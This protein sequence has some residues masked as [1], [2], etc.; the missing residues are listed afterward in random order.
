MASSHATESMSSTDTTKPASLRER[1]ERPPSLVAMVTERLRNAIVSGE[2]RLGEAVSEDKLASVF[3]VSRTPVREALTALQ[4]Q[5]LIDIRPQRG[6]FVFLP[7]VDEVKALCEFRMIMEGRAMALS[8]ARNRERTLDAM[9]RAH[10]AMQEALA[11]GDL[12]S[13]T[14]SDAELHDA[15]F[16]NCGNQYLAQAYAHMSGRI[17]TLRTHLSSRQQS[18]AENSM[19]EHREILEALALSDLGRAENLLSVHISRM[20]D[21][22]RQAL[23]SK[24][25]P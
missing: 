21:R 4:L 3:G 12:A 24:A 9:K 16:E 7:S 19:D 17:S 22:Y 6:S 5:G 14:R 15:F 13:L 20:S 11:R 25:L 18:I 8:L 10:A 1:L 23:D 2:F